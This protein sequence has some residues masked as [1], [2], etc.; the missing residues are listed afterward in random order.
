MDAY[1]ATRADDPS[2]FGNLSFVVHLSNKTRIGCANFSQLA[3]G[4]G[5]KPYPSSAALPLSTA[6]PVYNTTAPSTATATGGYSATPS[7]SIPA[8][9]TGAAAKMVAGPAALIA[10]MAAMVL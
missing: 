7:S 4:E 9:F 8:Q 2:F 1:L 3:P 10:V 6:A 5:V